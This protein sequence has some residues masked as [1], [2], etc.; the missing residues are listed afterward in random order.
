MLA[1][2]SLEDLGRGDNSTTNTHR[3]SVFFLSSTASR[4][5]E[6]RRAREE[7]S[8]NHM[9]VDI[10]LRCWL[11]SSGIFHPTVTIRAHM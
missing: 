6:K 1:D 9:F 10:S 11:V 7:I 5:L 4:K 2:P 3:D 8:V